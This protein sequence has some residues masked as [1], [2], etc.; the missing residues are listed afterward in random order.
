MQQELTAADNYRDLDNFWA[1]FS[2]RNIL[3]VHGNSFRRLPLYD[4]F[5]GL[6]AR[7]GL[8]V[9]HF[10]DFSP[11]PTREAVAAGVKFYRENRCD[12]VVAVG[13]GSAI[14]VAKGIKAFAVA[15]DDFSL[16]DSLAPPDIPFVAIPTTAGT[17][18]EATHFAVLYEEGKKYSVAHELLKPTA[19]LLDPVLLNDLPIYQR[20]VT[21]LDAV[22]H[23]IESMWSL[24]ATEVSRD[25]ARK[26]L[27]LAWK[28]KD[29]YVSNDAAANEQ[30][31]K[32]ANLAGQAID[33]S[34]T[35]A[36]HAMSY[37]LGQL[38][39]IAHGHAVAL[40]VA[41]LWRHLL[42]LADVNE[43]IRRSCAGIEAALGCS[44][45]EGAKKFADLP[46]QWELQID[47]L[48]DEELDD[49][50][51]SVNAQRLANHPA[52]L[53]REQIRE[54]YARIGRQP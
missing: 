31:L 26:A 40:C 24:Q 19:F 28:N 41:H 39:H 2:S 27:A 51:V 7:I 22:C 43:H 5:A 4:Y 53:S 49:L 10:T 32:G 38:R 1:K 21:A 14:D 36:G 47:P 9:H 8:T 23:S 42:T 37:R 44:A 50:E 54:L 17:G 12:T 46:A 15:A 20:K 18:S 13:G 52:K 6:S 45:A 30:M 48:T 29:G 35:T 3:L 25:F 11:N 34:K 16:A 33:I